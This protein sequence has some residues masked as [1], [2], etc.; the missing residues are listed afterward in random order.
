M[1]RSS[2]YLVDVQECFF[3]EQVVLLCLFQSTN[4][5]RKIHLEDN[6]T[7]FVLIVINVILSE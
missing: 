6:C 7:E 5:K 2:L 3:L 4:N 1:D